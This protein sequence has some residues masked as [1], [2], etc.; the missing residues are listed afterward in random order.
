MNKEVVM[1]LV[2]EA[3]DI[4]ESDSHYVDINVSTNRKGFIVTIY[5]HFVMDDLSVGIDD[6]RFFCTN[7]DFYLNRHWIDKWKTIIRSEREKNGPD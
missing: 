5:I 7:S 1:Q 2:G 6:C 4:G 3:Y